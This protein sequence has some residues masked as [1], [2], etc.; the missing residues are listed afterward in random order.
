MNK[1]KNFILILIVVGA[2]IL[3]V[4][5]WHNIAFNRPMDTPQFYFLDVGQG[6]SELVVFPGNIKVITDAGPDRSVVTAL[7]KALSGDHYLD[8]AVISHPQLDHYNGFNYLL[9]HYT[10]GAF[11]INGRDAP[12]PSKEWAALIAKIHA[13]HIPLLTLGAGDSIARDANRIEFLSPDSNFITS[14]ELNDTGLVE[15]IT[16]PPLTALFTADIGANVESYLVQKFNLVADIL[17][18]P[19]H[20]SKYSSSEPFLAAVQPKIE[21][22]EVGAGN[23][24]GHP[25]PETLIHLKN[26]VATRLFR[27]DQNGTVE[28]TAKEGSMQIFANR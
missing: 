17:K 16:A 8:L 9:D 13:E 25:A 18:V 4:F 19:H 27:T 23:R 26:A 24:Y 22:I 6:D 21:V 2:I 1:H 11:I 15:Y 12:P 28:I 20:G 3:D 5:L 10:V 14:D 7:E